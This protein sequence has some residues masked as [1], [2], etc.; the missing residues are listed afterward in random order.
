MLKQKPL[1]V[2]GAVT[3]AAGFGQQLYRVIALA[4][5]SGW[6]ML[7]VLGMSTIILASVIERHG[8][9]IKLKWSQ[10]TTNTSEDLD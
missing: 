10:L 6:V 7:A 9:V 3:V 5:F 4:D 8:A 1:L 2:L